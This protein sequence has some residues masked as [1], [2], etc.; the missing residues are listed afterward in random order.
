[1]RSE[2]S[3]SSIGLVPVS[4]HEPV[5]IRAWLSDNLLRAV[6][7]MCCVV[8]GLVVV[9]VA[10]SMYQRYDETYGR[11]EMAVLMPSNGWQVGEIRRDCT[12]VS[13]PIWIVCGDPLAPLHE[14][15]VRFDGNLMQAGNKVICT[16]MSD[17]FWCEASH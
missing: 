17:H 9:S 14:F 7:V 4:N 16:R 12:V 8:M 10:V 13:N 3:R 5:G 11:H 1:M 15:N 2:D 6:A